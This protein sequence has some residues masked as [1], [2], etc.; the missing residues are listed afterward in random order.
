MNSNLIKT[1][2]EFLKI[3]LDVIEIS[4]SKQTKYINYLNS[5]NNV[6]IEVNKKNKTVWF[7]SYYITYSIFDLLTDDNNI[8]IVKNFLSQM[9][10]KHLGYKNYKINF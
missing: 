10:T 6:V 1:E 8:E 4:K 9:V 7:N 2:I 3:L 5:N